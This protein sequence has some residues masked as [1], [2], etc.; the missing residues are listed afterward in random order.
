MIG[1]LLPAELFTILTLVK[2]PALNA[3]D[4]AVFE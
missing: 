2:S 3:I 1:A 4:V